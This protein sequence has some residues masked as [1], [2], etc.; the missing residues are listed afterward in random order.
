VPRILQIQLQQHLQESVLV[1]TT[2]KQM[3]KALLKAKILVI[4]LY[5]GILYDPA[6]AG[7]RRDVG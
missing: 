1:P 7:N 6:F 5:N 4:L 3:D 2:K